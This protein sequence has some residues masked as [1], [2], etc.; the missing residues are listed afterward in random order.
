MTLVDSETVSLLLDLEFV[1]Q[2]LNLLLDHLLSDS[3]SWVGVVDISFWSF[4]HC[5]GIFALICVL[6]FLL[7]L[8]AINAIAKIVL[9]FLF[10]LLRLRHDL[11]LF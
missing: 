11:D 5:R 2:T 10:R 8:I 6:M 3:S 1:E 7:K 9:L 4:V